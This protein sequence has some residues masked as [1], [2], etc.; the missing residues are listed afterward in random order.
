MKRIFK[1]VV[2]VVI[3][4]VFV[5]TFYFLYQKS[6]D[7]PK[8]YKTVK[9]I[10]TDIIKKS[11]AT[12]SINPRKEIQ[13]KP[14]IS[15]IID[16]IYIKSGQNLKK[17]DPI[18]RIKIIPDMINLNNAENRLNKAII[19]LEDTEKTYKIQKNLYDK[20]I[21]NGNLSEGKL[22]P[23]L[24]KYNNAKYRLNKA[25]LA[26]EDA[27]KTYQR[28]KTLYDKSLKKGTLSESND[29]YNMIKL[30]NAEF[31][32]NNASL[33]IQ[34]TRKTYERH[35]SLFQKSLVSESVLQQSNLALRRAREELIEAKNNYNLVKEE[36]T[37]AAKQRFQ[38]AEINLRQAQGELIES[39]NNFLLVKE[40]VI[41]DT[42]EQYQKAEV[43]LKKAQEEIVS[44]RNNLQL[45]KDGFIETN[46]NN[47]NTIIK[48]TID[49]MI[50][51]IPV[52]EGNLVIESNSNNAGTT[53]AAVADMND[54]IFEGNIDESEVGKLNFGMELILSIGAIET[55]KF[56]AVLE[57]ISPKGHEKNGA[58]QFKIRAN[59]ELKETFFVRAGYSANADIVL[60]KQEKVIAINEAALIIEKDK[61]YVEVE[62]TSQVF[63]KRLITTGLSD[64]ISIE[65][66]T[67]LAMEDQIKLQ[68]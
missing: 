45:I 51:D 16:H 37:D 61:T 46:D 5:G 64:G 15:G 19:T 17:G 58:I 48:S 53:V 28:E 40:E 27:N 18:A 57:Y 24:I 68:N 13:I 9:P 26:L 42:E 6:L 54:M 67:G 62:T 65:V 50:L 44:A 56:K 12:G 10:I 14:H 29:S 52:K 23:N 41:L 35:L 47:A 2:L 43:T 38:T 11:V 21:V 34:D 20:S 22:T 49:G 63:E 31:R 7:K 66:V 39:E 55:E 60:D 1:Y 32:V 8:Q 30:S 3:L 59:L 36:T 4:V 25:G 33:A